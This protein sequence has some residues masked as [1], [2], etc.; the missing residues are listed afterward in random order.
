MSFGIIA[1][2]SVYQILKIA[3]LFFIP[4]GYFLINVQQNGNF[5]FRNTQPSAGE[6]TF[7]QRRNIRS[8]N[9]FIGNRLQAF[10]IRLGVIFQIF[11]VHI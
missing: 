4:I 3:A 8:V 1:Q 5:S 6:K 2:G 10:P 7:V 9:F 11:L